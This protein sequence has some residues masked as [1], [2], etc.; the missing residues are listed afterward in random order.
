MILGYLSR[1][2][3]DPSLGEELA[4]ETFYRATRAFL[5]WRGGAPAAWLLAIARNVLVDHARK[6]KR[7]VPL[8]VDLA[9]DNDVSPP[10]LGVRATLE[11]L[12]GRQRRLLELV[13]LDGFSHAE[14]AAMAGSTEG[15]VKTAVYRARE[16][17]RT[18]HRKEI[19]DD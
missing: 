14:V 16:A 6:G 10:D 9:S 7:L 3:G 5:G 13:Y 19:H 15:A 2:T 11:C 17:F 12:S 18:A 1:R 4:Q 8:S